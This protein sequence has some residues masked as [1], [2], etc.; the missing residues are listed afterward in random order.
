LPIRSAPQDILIHTDRMS[1]GQLPGL[2]H[3]E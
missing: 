3:L 2:Y 1:P